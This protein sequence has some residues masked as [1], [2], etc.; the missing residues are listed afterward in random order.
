MVINVS[1][2]VNGSADDFAKT[3]KEH[4]RELTKIVKEQLE[5][6]LRVKF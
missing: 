3:A 2:I 1:Y 4:G 5:R 6:E